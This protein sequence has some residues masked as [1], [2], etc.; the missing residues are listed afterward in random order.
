MSVLWISAGTTHAALPRDCDDNSIIKCGATS[1]AELSE[2]FNE[3]KT[4]DL[5][6]IYSSYGISA[7]DIAN[8]STIAKMGEVR[9]DG[10]IVVDGQVVATGA[11]S[12][13]RQDIFS[14]SSQKKIGDKVFYETAPAGSFMRDSI[15]AH[16]FFNKD[17]EFKAAILTSCGNP[18]T[19]HPPKKPPVP[20]PVPQYECTILSARTIKLEDRHYAFDLTYV[21][22]KG[23][24]LQSVDYDFGDKQTATNLTPAGAKTIEH[25][26]A[27]AGSYTTVATLHFK[28]PGSATVVDKKCAVGVT[29][30]QI[31]EMCPQNP[32]VPKGD[33]R[34]V[35]PVHELPK[36]GPMDMI[37]TGVGLSS[38]L[39]AGY[40]WFMSRKDLIAASMNE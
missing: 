30:T 10:T 3:N 27:K 35:T 6:A 23:A 8:A 39:V 16:V 29:P 19:G 38:I 11:M 25:K 36:T 31:Q 33:A 7:A 32:S 4:N 17:G 2:R 37:G 26:Y 14:G 9:K 24:V 34:C 1:A 20:V 40:Y 15:A 28:I 18:V 13:G 22:E 5:P 12:I 21:A